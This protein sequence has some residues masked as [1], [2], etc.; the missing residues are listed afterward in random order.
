MMKRVVEYF[1]DERGVETLEWILIGGLIV[2]VGVA[3]YPGVLEPG[4]SGVITTI[5]NTVTTAVQ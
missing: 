5:V 4:L 1:R 2:G 3:V